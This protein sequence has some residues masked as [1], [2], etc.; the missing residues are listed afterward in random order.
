M[1]KRKLLIYCF[2]GFI[3]SLN[4]AINAE[5]LNRN[6]FFHRGR[7]LIGN[8]NLKRKNSKQIFLTMKNKNSSYLNDE[9]KP[10]PIANPNLININGPKISIVLN[11]T[12]A[13]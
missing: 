10:Y 2:S 1:V 5:T 4:L 13:K 3:L 12:P 8:S 9:F 6:F 7:V 11:K